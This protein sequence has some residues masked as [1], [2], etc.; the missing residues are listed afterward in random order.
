MTQL[1]TIAIVGRTNVGKST[2]FNR[3]LEKHRAIVSAIA[4]TTRDRN[5]GCLE[6]RGRKF[7]IIDTGGLD[8]KNPDEIETNIIKQTKLAISQADIILFLVDYQVGIVSDDRNIAKQLQGAREKIMLVVN[9][10][11]KPQDRTMPS[12]N[13]SL[14]GIKPHFISAIT[15]AGTG[16]LLDE[17]VK[18]IPNYGKEKESKKLQTIR[19]GIIGRPNVGKSSL[20]NKIIQEERVIVSPIP[21]TTREPQDVALRF[22]DYEIILV[23]TAGI[24]KKT[25]SKD[26]IIKKGIEKTLKKIKQLDIVLFVI[27]ANTLLTASDSRIAGEILENGT[28]LILVAN[29]WDLVEEKQPT[30]VNEFNRY[31]Y[32]HFPYLKWVPII[33][34]SALTGQRCKKILPLIIDVYNERVK[35]LDTYELD[36]YFQKVIAQKLPQSKIRSIKKRYFYTIAQEYQSPPKFIIRT[37]N[38]KPIEQHY[39]HYVKNKLRERFQF[40]GTPISVIVKSVKR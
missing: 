12:G 7:R 31:F 17:L 4:G 25:K 23:D 6:W 33:F 3:L 21:H 20:L 15:G 39:I 19:V 40:V 30:T 2:L 14:L 35:Q 34:T 28:S 26:S 18:K 37:N 29:K 1:P 32:T 5:I 38:Q 36:N 10:T 8:L 9:K 11:D 24:V 22:Q 13:F 16:D 27:E